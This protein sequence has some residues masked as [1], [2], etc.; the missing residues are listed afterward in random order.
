RKPVLAV[1]VGQLTTV[2]PLRSAGGATVPAYGDPAVAAG[3]LAAVTRYAAWLRRPS[4]TV[5][6]LPGIDVGS[7]PPLGGGHLARPPDWGG[8]L[9]ARLV[10]A[11]LRCF[12]L[13]FVD[14]VPVSGSN[15]AN[16]ADAA[17]RAAR[18]L[19]FPVAVKAEATGVLH[20]S[21]AGGVLLGLRDEAQ[22]RAAVETLAAR[23]GPD[24]TGVLVQPM[25]E[26]GREL[27]VGVHG[28]ATF[29]PLVVLGVGGGAP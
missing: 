11:L 26:P 27:L 5:P 13:P 23:F 3:A 4:R 2:E 29:G 1:R 20:K 9:R 12:G 24:L 17:V 28:D 18:E 21:Q 19:G 8:G 14:S 22:V 25:V 10:S 16:T 15:A 6:Q 7:A